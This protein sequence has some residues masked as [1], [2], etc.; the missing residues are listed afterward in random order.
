[1]TP[2]ISDEE[3]EHLLKMKPML[4]MFGITPSDSPQQMFEKLF[5]PSKALQMTIFSTQKSITNALCL[6]A[7]DH[8]TRPAF[9]ETV[10]DEKGKNTE[11]L[12][13]GIPSFPQWIYDNKILGN[14]STK[15]SFFA[16][17]KEMFIQNP[18]DSI[19]SPQPLSGAVPSQKRSLSD[20]LLGRNKDE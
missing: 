20:K 18:P 9:Y 13:T 16:G 11:Q 1:M 7:V 2:Q 10:T 4:Q 6:G 3:I 8:L 14:R 17:F 12:R 19:V 5:D 15:G